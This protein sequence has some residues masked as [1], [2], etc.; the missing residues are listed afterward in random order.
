MSV[1]LPSVL[2]VPATDTVHWGV[3]PSYDTYGGTC[4][5][6]QDA[7]GL[8]QVPTGS[9]QTERSA[10]GR[11]NT[12]GVRDKVPQVCVQFVRCK[13]LCSASTMESTPKSW[14]TGRAPDTQLPV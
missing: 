2:D 8:A 9:L 6:M 12:R 5:R 7:A 14:G 3:R 10:Q 4:E 13:A 1:S 11:P